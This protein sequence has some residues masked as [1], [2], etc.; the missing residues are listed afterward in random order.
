MFAT[1][2]FVLALLALGWLMG[3][4]LP[5]R[6]SWG[7]LPAV[8]MVGSLIIDLVS[9]R[10]SVGSFLSDSLFILA[11]GAMASCLGH[12]FFGKQSDNNQHH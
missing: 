8:M 1:F 6:S 9:P 10:P 2:I 12:F 11:I 3:R 7:L 4:A 5:F